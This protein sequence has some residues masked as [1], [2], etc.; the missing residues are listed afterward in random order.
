MHNSFEGVVSYHCRIVLGIDR[1]DEQ[2]CQEKPTD[3]CQLAVA[4]NLLARNSTP[5]WRSLETMTI[6]VLKVLCTERGIAL[7][8]IGWGKQLKKAEIVDV[9]YDSLVSTISCV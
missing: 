3:P 5:S 7:P 8:V 9:I 2:H 1:P 4:Q 6:V